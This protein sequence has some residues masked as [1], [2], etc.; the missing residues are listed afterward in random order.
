MA[1]NRT[2]QEKQHDKIRPTGHGR[3][4]DAQ[5]QGEPGKAKK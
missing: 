2:Q 5:K 3:Q 4:R 1:D